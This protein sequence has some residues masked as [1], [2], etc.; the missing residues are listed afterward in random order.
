MQPFWSVIVPVYDR[1]TYLKQC[2]DSVLQQDA[3]PEELEILV[4]DDASPSDLKA[5][6]ESIGRGRVN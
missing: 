5:F 3:R 6:V 1:R 2:L 4:I